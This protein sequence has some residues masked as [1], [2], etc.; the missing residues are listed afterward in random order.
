MPPIHWNDLLK[1][2]RNRQCVLFVGPDLLPDVRLFPELCTFLGGNADGPPPDVAACYPHEELFLFAHPGARMNVCFRLDDFHAA[3][4]ERFA[5]LYADLAALP[6]PL[7]ISTLPDHGLHQAFDRAG[8]AHQFQAYN[9]RGHATAGIQPPRQQ[10]LLFNLFG[11]C[12]DANSLVLDHDDLFGFL[13]QFMGARK[14]SDTHIEIQEMLGSGS[15]IFIF[16]GF[17]FDKW[18]MQILLHLLNPG[19]FK[20]RQYALNS[21]S[22][23]E[24]RVFFGK[25]FQV[26]FVDA[27]TP[28]AFLAELV[29][30]WQADEQARQTSPAATTKTNL[31]DWLKSAQTERVL[32]ELEKMFQAKHD[33]DGLHRITLLS[34]RWAKL[35]LAQ[36]KGTLSTADAN[37]ESNRL[38]DA[39]LDLINRVDEKVDKGL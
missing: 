22:A 21:A 20:A 8:V 27:L 37:L 34:A 19:K 25:K 26:E 29:S 38:Q 39:L 14:L 15:T 3:W 36:Y 16:L 18:Y 7:I 4:Q 31:R 24:T 9:F 2:L 10:R 23:K 28:A 6:I 30:R 35:E 33:Q 12:A 32:T 17:Q 1:A 11:D 5:P 13:A